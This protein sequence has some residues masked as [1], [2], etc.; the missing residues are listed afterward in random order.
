MG[1]LRS[2]IVKLHL[3]FLF[4]ALQAGSLFA[5]GD[6]FSHQ[7]Q[8]L[9]LYLH[10]ADYPK[11]L[12]MGLDLVQTTTKSS[13]TSDPRIS[14]A[15]QILGRAYTTAGLYAEAEM[16]LR[17]SL[18]HINQYQGNQAPAAAVVYRA[19]ATNS[20]RSGDLASAPE[21]FD[22]SVD[23]LTKA[24]PKLQLEL[25]EALSER[26]NM[27]FY[28]ED[29]DA[30]EKDYK[31]AMKIQ[32]AKLGFQSPELARSLNNMGGVYM[33]QG[34]FQKAKAVYQHAYNMQ[35]AT[36]GG[37]APEVATTLVNLAVYHDQMAEFELAESFLMQAL[38]LRTLVHGPA[39]PLVG[40]VIDNL[41][42]LYLSLDQEDK[43]KALL[44]DL[45]T[46]RTQLHGGD[47]PLVADVLDK[48]AAFALTRE[49]GQEAEA[50][51]KEALVIREAYYGSRH[52]QVAATLYNLGKLQN[53]N[54]QPEAAR[55][56]LT[57]AL[58]IYEFEP[59]GNQAAL[60]GILAELVA[61]DLAQ[62]QYGLA[63]GHLLTI[64]N[65]KEMAFGTEHPEVF[66][67]HQ[68]LLRFYQQTEQPEKIMATQ[69][70]ISNFR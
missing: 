8:Q 70:L 42:S 54:R 55:L 33:R 23:L 30:A 1:S 20:I 37:D 65:I 21:F 31:A 49:R 34:H 16:W 28:Q 56:T 66:G 45:K 43:A 41:I 35:K 11:A 64:L 22:L 7:K 60:C 62:S 53:I 4:L 18:S 48:Q 67:V 27:H 2:P 40:T 14:E 13:P 61:T 3:I 25:A 9:E 57:K 51:L 36:L 59:T 68:E 38:E 24:T 19:L 15:M 63:E 10:Q 6:Q 44:V 50:F 12:A 52:D 32:E 29:W 46:S 47:H 26:A 69:E 39:H 17:R 58:D 5:Q